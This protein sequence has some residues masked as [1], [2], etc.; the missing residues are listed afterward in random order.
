MRKYRL[1]LLLR[2]GLSKEKRDKLILEIKKW[3]GDTKNLKD[4]ST[5][6]KKLAYPI[7]K[8]KSA[9]FMI[10]NFEAEKYSPDLDKK[11][12]MEENILRHLIVRND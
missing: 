4:E 10:I 12:L 1:T 3:I 6:E 5:G 7:N 9:E 8:E 2:S 11:L